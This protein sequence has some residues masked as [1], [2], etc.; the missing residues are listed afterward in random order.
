[1]FYFVL[2]YQHHL[3]NLNPSYSAAHKL[4]VALADPLYAPQPNKS[5]HD[6]K[7]LY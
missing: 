7:P 4:E 3:Q 6:M 5:F 2:V 1:M